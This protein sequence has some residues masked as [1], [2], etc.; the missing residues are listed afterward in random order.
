M[1][2][3]FHECTNNPTNKSEWDLFLFRFL[4]FSC[5]KLSPSLLK[6]VPSAASST[7]GT[8]YGP[9]LTPLMRTQK[10]AELD[11]HAAEWRCSFHQIY[12]LQDLVT[13]SACQ[14]WQWLLLKW[15]RR[16]WNPTNFWVRMSRVKFGLCPDPTVLAPSAKCTALSSHMQWWW[17]F[18]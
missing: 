17:C 11:A 10:F 7:V 3:L 6:P 4:F 1:C 12:S 16:S 8:G 2:Q 18:R 5:S 14:H 9:N 13:C 15:R